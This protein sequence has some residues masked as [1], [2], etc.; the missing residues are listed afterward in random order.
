M[1]GRDRA[2]RVFEIDKINLKKMVDA[3]V[4]FGFGTNSGG[5]PAGSSCRA[6]LSTG[7]WN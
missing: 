2:M 4:R 5:A 7:R 6:S 3:G 1:Q